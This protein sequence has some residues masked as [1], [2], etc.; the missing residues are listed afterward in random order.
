MTT[1]SAARAMRDSSQA[2]WWRVRTT[3]V[4]QTLSTNMVLAFFAVVVL[5]SPR[6]ACGR[7]LI[8]LAAGR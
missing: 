3:T 5:S 4:M 7:P 8:A 1:G 2:P 6:A